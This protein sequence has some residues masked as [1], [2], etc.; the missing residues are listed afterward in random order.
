MHCD[1]EGETVRVSV[2]E[3]VE[4]SVGVAEPH[5]ENDFVRV[6]LFVREGEGLAEGE[7]A[8]ERDEDTVLEGVGEAD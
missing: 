1:P 4:Y 6:T 2:T 7:R 3:R 8:D 5:W